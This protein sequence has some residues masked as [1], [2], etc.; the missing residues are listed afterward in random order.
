M[1]YRLFAEI[2]NYSIKYLLALKT[3]NKIK[4]KKAGRKVFTG[5]CFYNGNVVDKS[6]FTKILNEIKSEAKGICIGTYIT[7]NDGNFISRIV[8]LP[9]SDEKDI[10]KH[11]ALEAGHYL[12]INPETFEV[13]FRVIEKSSSVEGITSKILVSAGPLTSIMGILECFDKCGLNPKV[14]DAYPNSICRLYEHAEEKSAAVIDLGMHCVNIT[15]LKGNEFYM[16]SYI[17]AGLKSVIDNLAS[18]SGSVTE[19]NG[20]Y[21]IIDRDFTEQEEVLQSGLP[22]LMSQISRYL[23]Y[24]NSRHFGK[25][26]DRIYVIGDNAMLKGLKSIMEENFKT[27]IAIGLKELPLSI[28]SESNDITSY[29]SLIGLAMRCGKS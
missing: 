25:T 21:S 2:D 14:I 4:I 22:E 3:R 28:S 20:D 13:D 16:H 9:I 19:K 23:D 6:Y 18:G 8:E 15:I 11:L 29:L 27:D 7:I 1:F 5:V 26:V 10:E 24:Y 17:P 12:P